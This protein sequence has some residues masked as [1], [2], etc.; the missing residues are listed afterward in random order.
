[1]SVLHVVE[2]GLLT[3]VQDLGRP[4]FGAE[5]V[6][7]SGAADGVS[8]AVA[9]RLAGNAPGAPAIEMTLVGGTFRLDAGGVVGIAGSDFGATIDGRPAPAWRAYEVAPGGTVRFGSTRD[10]AR[11]Y[12]AVR[13]GIVVPP[14]LGSASTHLPSGLGGFE[15]RPLRRGDRLEIGGSPGGAI[16]LEPGAIHGIVFRKTLRVV[17]GPQERWFAPEARRAFVDS[18]FVVGESSDRTGV[19]LEGPILA[20]EPARSLATEGVLPGQVQVT[21]DGRAIVLGV[22]GPTTGGYPKIA[23]VIAADLAALG[24]LR[25]RDRVRF[26]RVEAGL[27]RSEW[28]RVRAIVAAGNGRD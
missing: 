3:T 9:N 5:G 10:G 1:M 23:G 15:G 28:A 2:P 22:D 4:G 24:Q 21:P 14:F 17:A 20:I 7:V 11:A 6:A 27:A 16:D 19:R 18:E 25:P 13:G 8:L 12:L 26:E